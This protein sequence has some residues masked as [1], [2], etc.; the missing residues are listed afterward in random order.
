MIQCDFKPRVNDIVR[1]K[2]YYKKRTLSSILNFQQFYN[3]DLSTH[4]MTLAWC[5]E[6]KVW[7]HI[8]VY[9]QSW[10]FGKSTDTTFFFFQDFYLFK[11]LKVARSLFKS[12]KCF[13][14]YEVSGFREAV[15]LLTPWLYQF[16]WINQSKVK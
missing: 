15:E 11:M 10:D 9:V 1:M 4:L 6:H 3:R 16:G 2:N 14:L 12:E 5:L 13:Q 7:I 8:Q